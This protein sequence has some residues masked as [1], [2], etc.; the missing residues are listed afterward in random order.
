[1]AKCQN[2]GATM[3]CGCQKRVSPDGK[4]GCTKCI[5]NPAQPAKPEPAK[6]KNLVSEN[7][8]DPFAPIINNAALKV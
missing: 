7:T 1:M 4:V 5:N 6:T 8:L 3:S 2:C